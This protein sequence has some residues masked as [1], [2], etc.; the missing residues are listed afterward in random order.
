MRVSLSWL[1]K[2]VDIRL[3]PSEL[4]SALTMAG[5]E[6]EA[7]HKSGNDEIFELSITP[8]RG[9]CLCM[10]G[11]ARDVAAITG[12]KLAL[13]KVKLPKCAGKI[14]DYVKVQIKSPAQ[15]PR[16]TSRVIEG[17]KVGPSPKWMVEA[18]ESAGMRSINNVVDATNYVMFELGQPLH[19]FDISKIRRN[20]IVVGVAGGAKK[21]KTLDGEVRDIVATDLL[22]NDG[23]GPVA[24]AGVM[25]G[26]DSG[27]CDSTTTL[28]LESAYFEPTGIRK[29]SKRL[30]L[31]SESSRRFERGIDPNGADFALARLTQI[32]WET[33]GGVP[34]VDFADVY[35]KKIKPLN[36]ILPQ[37]EVSRILGLDLSLPQITKIL[38]SLGFASVNKAAG[39]LNVC[40]PTFRPDVERPIDIIEEIARIHGY[41]KI[42]TMLPVVRAHSISRPKFYKEEGIVRTL[43]ADGGLNEVVTL[44]FTNQSKLESFITGDCGQIN[45][46]NPIS[47]DWSVMSSTLLPGILDAAALN[48]NRQRT[49]IRLFALQKT[50]SKNEKSAGSNETRRVAAIISGRR[51]VNGWERARELVDF[52]DI[53]AYTG[54]IVSRF[55]LSG[56]TT[57]R[58]VE[59][60]PFLQPG[61]AVCLE[62]QGKR[63]G[64]LGKLHPEVAKK[65]EFDKDIYSFELDFEGLIG[66]AHGSHT[67][68]K[69]YSKFPF[70][71][72]DLALILEDGASSEEVIEAVKSAGVGILDDAWVF[73]VFRGGNIEKGRK[74][75]ALT[76]KLARKDATLTDDEVNAAQEKI[77][78]I[79]KVKLG[80][81]LRI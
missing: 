37:A 23:E 79:L 12:A 72:R 22:I 7:R 13:P 62:V 41:G 18:L 3:L 11:V 5:I 75:L 56:L 6:V 46:S 27:V 8:N 59:D 49:D 39:K 58:H 10:T 63:I 45:L 55:G 47:S 19:A 52:Y 51:F 32:I 80:A 43:L 25:G 42:K 2:Y 15:C 67:V 31:I 71:E 77:V 61:L 4:A 68:F 21:F 57:Y 33:A 81:D 54:L 17:V 78:N 29:T 34:T 44:S 30:G 36:I 66:F 53:K 64:W 38:K 28:L 35:P 1:K 14:S 24:L 76:I 20:A 16:Y 69:E 40:V 48:L 65:W 70:V 50:F 9:D 73:D 74:S 26:E 60:Y